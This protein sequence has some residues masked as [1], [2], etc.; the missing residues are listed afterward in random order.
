MERGGGGEGEREEEE[1]FTDKNKRN[2]RGRRW[3]RPRHAKEE[4][5][6]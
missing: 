4:E 1:G 5:G 6:G 2:K 3:A